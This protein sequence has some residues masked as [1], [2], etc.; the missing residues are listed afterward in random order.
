LTDEQRVMELIGLVDTVG[1]DLVLTTGG[2][3]AASHSQ[4]PIDAFSLREN[5]LTMADAPW[6]NT[7]CADS[8]WMALHAERSRGVTP[9]WR[10]RKADDQPRSRRPRAGRPA[11]TGRVLFESH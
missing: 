4:V 10:N 11:G 9:H 1:C 5:R 8:T 3:G 7:I 2:T 6:L